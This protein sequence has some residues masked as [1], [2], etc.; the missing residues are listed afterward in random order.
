M[1]KDLSNQQLI[2][3][4]KENKEFLE[5]IQKKINSIEKLGDNNEKI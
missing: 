4:Y 1:Y 2:D 5:Y 3:L